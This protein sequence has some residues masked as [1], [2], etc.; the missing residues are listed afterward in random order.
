MTGRVLDA[1]GAPLRAARV[2]V[3]GVGVTADAHIAAWDAQTRAPPGRASVPSLL[4]AHTSANPD[5]S[6]E[7]P[8]VPPDVALR[9]VAVHPRH[10]PAIS[11]PLVLVDGAAREIELRL[12]AR[13]D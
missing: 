3:V 5:G 1:S 8:R 4:A 2:F 12:A 11:A 7:L 9:V 6:F 13:R 10:D